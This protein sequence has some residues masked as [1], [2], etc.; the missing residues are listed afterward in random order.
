MSLI[1]NWLCLLILLGFTPLNGQDLTEKT[2]V[3]PIKE[4]TVF[5][6]SAQIYRVSNIQLEEGRFL[7]KL[8]NL[9]PYLDP[10][11][12]QV[13]SKGDLVTL[14]VNH[15]LNYLYEHDKEGQLVD[16]SRIV[17]SI[18][19]V[20]QEAEIRLEVLDEKQKLLA[21]NRSLGKELNQIENLKSALD[22]Y[23]SALS[24]LKS[25]ALTIQRR[26]QKLRERK[27]KIQKQIADLNA[28]EQLPSSEIIIRIDV[29]SAGEVNFKISYLVDNAGWFPKY[30]VRINSLNDPLKLT[31]QADVYQNTRVDW[32]NIKL[33][34][35]NTDP[36]KSGLNPTLETWLLTYDRY[37]VFESQ[38]QRQNTGAVSGTVMDENGEALI[39]ASVY[40]QGTS[41][42]A[43][44]DIN[45]RFELTLPSN[46]AFLVVSYVGFNSKEIPISG[47]VI[48]VRMESDMALE[49]VV[50]TGYALEGRAAGL[51]TKGAAEKPKPQLITAT[52]ENATSVSFELAEPYTLKANGEQRRIDL[53]TYEINALYTYYAIPKLDPDAYLIAKIT[54][55]A[56]YNLLSGEANLYFE[57]AFVGRTILEGDVL[58]DTLDIS[59]GSDQGISIQR[60]KVDDFTKTRKIGNNNVVSQGFRFSVRNNKSTQVHLIIQD[61]L[62]IAAINE[63]EIRP[64]QL[65]KGILN[66]QTGSVQWEL[67][68]RPLE[69]KEIDFSYE[70]K[71]PKK[72]KISIH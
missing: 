43:V 11:S 9:S 6:N 14:S 28:Q 55:W 51:R 42:G 29:K 64:T 46:A 24:S 58:S 8:P 49:E 5:L 33:R 12:I 60:E 72:E 40:V 71:Y 67:V 68:L 53:N 3:A 39:G 22:F 47:S 32:D 36:K 13:A 66:T 1:H 25:E 37:T 31:Y 2:L 38:Y 26:L 21:E 69:Q 57:E 59:L 54:D 10:K 20:S 35:S 4:A 16:L 52:I 18:D 61:Q 44:T 27:N 7:L 30:D 19:F 45:G 65:S 17:D 23:D 56:K 70:I 48:N 15:G 63:I 41:I 62:P 34:F 50:V